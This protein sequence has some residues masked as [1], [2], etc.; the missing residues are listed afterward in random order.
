MRSL[1]K[2]IFNGDMKGT[3]A[4]QHFS[5]QN[6]GKYL[7]EPQTKTRSV[8]R[9][10]LAGRKELISYEES[11]GGN[12]L[13]SLRACHVMLNDGEASALCFSHDSERQR[14]MLRR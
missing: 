14:Q 12:Y 6:A 13:G 1:S 11:K 3:A 9:K 10:D 7:A 8:S 4:C 5:D 2:Q